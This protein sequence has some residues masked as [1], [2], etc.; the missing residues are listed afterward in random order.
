MNVILE[1]KNIIKDY[2]QVRAV[3]GVSLSIKQGIC[4]GLLGPN[5]AGKS[6]LMKVLSGVYHSDG[7]EIIF[8]GKMVKFADPL[9]AKRI[10]IEMVYQDLALCDNMSIPE[11][12]Y[13]ADKG[14][15]QMYVCEK[16]EKKSN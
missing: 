7:G 10:G 2:P 12:I 6:T 9:H 8:E 13:D 1:V 5:G 16:N 14:T 15:A 11:N 4:F 3:D